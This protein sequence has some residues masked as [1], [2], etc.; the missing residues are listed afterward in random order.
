MATHKSMLF[1]E[2]VH[3][4][5]LTS[6]DASL[7]AKQLSHDFSSGHVLAQCMDVISVGGAHIVILTK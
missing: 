2:H 1:G 5:S 3:G 7:L 6:T 4:A